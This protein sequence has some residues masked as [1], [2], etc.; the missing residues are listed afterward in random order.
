MEE[1]GSAFKIL[2]G[3]PAGKRPLERPGR[4][5]NDNIIMDLKEIDINT[6]IYA[7]STQDRDYWKSLVNA[8]LNL[9]VSLA[10]LVNPS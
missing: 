2:V 4:R 7:V 9:R 6:R 10:K 5:W 3:I 8:P 1:H